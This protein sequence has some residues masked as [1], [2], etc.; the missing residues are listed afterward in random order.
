MAEQ[1]Y[2]NRIIVSIQYLLCQIAWFHFGLILI[3]LAITLK[4]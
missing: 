4:W 2:V 1:K 3:R